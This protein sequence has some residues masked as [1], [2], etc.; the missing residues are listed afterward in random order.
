MFLNKL[1]MIF[2]TTTAQRAKIT[3]RQRLINGIFK[4]IIIV[5]VIVM[6]III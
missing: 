1:L 6:I 2:K 4:S 3:P 5:G